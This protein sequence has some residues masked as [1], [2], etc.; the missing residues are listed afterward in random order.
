M[1]DIEINS[2]FSGEQKSNLIDFLNIK[3][4]ELSREIELSTLEKLIITNKFT[5][6]VIRIQ[7]EYESNEYGHTNRDDGI[8]VAKVLSGKVN[9]KLSQTIVIN[10]YILEDLFSSNQ[11]V[12]Q[13]SFHTLHHELCHVHDGFYQ[14]IMFSQEARMGK[15][16]SKLE[17]NLV[18]HA[19]VIWGEYIAVRLSA[20]SIPIRDASIALYTDDLRLSNLFKQIESCEKNLSRA[21]IEY[22][23]HRDIDKLFKV[24]QEDVSML[25]II[26]ATVQGYI[27][28]LGLSNDKE[29]MDLVDENIKQT[30]FYEVWVKQCESL[31]ML[32]DL[33]PNWNDVYELKDLGKV[34]QLCWN[35]LGIY[36]KD[37]PEKDYFWISVPPRLYAKTP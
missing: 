30:Y 25:L 23:L 22:R 35:K 16:L 36:P 18:C 29:M 10:D 20:T 32:Y 27:D 1:V 12:C 4:T 34:I 26:A 11:T 6:D 28:G 5:D 19:N 13:C 17:H 2:S 15:G 21:I 3:I 37:I 24:F 7:K 33:Y 14:D 9:G 8:A 31:R